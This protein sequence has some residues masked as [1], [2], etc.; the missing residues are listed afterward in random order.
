MLLLSRLFEPYVVQI[1]S[2]LLERFGDVSASVRH[3]T[4]SVARAVMRNLSSQGELS[5][6]IIVLCWLYKCRFIAVPLST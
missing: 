2:K 1:M 6:S 4:N 3:A 5:T